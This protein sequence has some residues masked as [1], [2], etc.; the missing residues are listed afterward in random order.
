MVTAGQFTLRTQNMGCLPVVNFF[1]ARDG[2]GRPSADLPAPRRRTSAAGPGGGDRLGGA[3][4]RGWSPTGLRAAL[5]RSYVG[6]EPG[7][8]R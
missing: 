3:Q 1:L 7:F 5:T 4:H 8:P 6:S 2:P